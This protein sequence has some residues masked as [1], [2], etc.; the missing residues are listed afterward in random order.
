MF[1]ASSS[2]CTMANVS[3][4]KGWGAELADQFSQEYF[5]NLSAFVKEEYKTQQ[6]YPPG[7]LIFQ[8]FDACPWD[9]VNV[10]ILGQDPYIN[11]GQAHGLSFS[12]PDGVPKPPSLLNIFK[13]IKN[14]T[15][16]PVPTSGNLLRWANQGVLLLNSV[17]TVRAGL[18]NSHQGKGWEIFTDAVIRVLSEKKSHLVFMLWGNFA[19]QKAVLIDSAKHLILESPHPSPMSVTRGFFGNGHFMKCNESLSHHGNNPIIW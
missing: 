6:I 2:I 16:Q 11:P 8:A 13:E 19:R 5:L 7:K 18:S 3:I 15:G 12:V 14:E 10:V 17:L 4:E 9:T 1:F